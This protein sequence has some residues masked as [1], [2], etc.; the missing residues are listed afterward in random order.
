MIKLIMT[1]YIKD[2]L[3]AEYLEFLTKRFTKMMAEMGVQPTDAWYAAWG[4]GPQVIAGGVTSD[5]AQMEAALQSEQWQALKKELDRL[6]SG[7]EYKVV[8]AAGGFQL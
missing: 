4:Q 8:Q 7:F 3:E 2:G 1:W 5:R 6:V